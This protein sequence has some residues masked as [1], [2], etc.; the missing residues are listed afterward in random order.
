MSTYY[1][2]FGQTL[3]DLI[4]L[5]LLIWL[6]KVSGD[7]GSTKRS[8]TDDFQI[9]EV[10]VKEMREIAEN[11]DKNLEQKKILSHDILAR[12]NEGLEQAETYTKRIEKIN[13]A[14]GYQLSERVSDLK[15]REQTRASIQA[16]ISKGFSREEI[17]RHLGITQG[18]I[19]LLIKLQPGKVP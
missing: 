8:S 16:L 10:L 13:E 14:Y 11:L 19:E 9:P 3:I 6:I 17:A 18:E 15:D 7:K 5:T 12:L 1:L 4:I 2:I